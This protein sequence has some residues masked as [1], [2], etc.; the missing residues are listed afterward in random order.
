MFLGVLINYLDR[1]NISHTIL[2][3]SQELHLS[4]T[5]QGVILSS[6]S[7]GYVLFM[8]PSGWLV[9][10]Y[11]SRIVCA[12]SCIAWSVSTAMIG[13]AN[14]FT[15][16][17]VCR[18]LLGA[19]EAPIF[20]ANAKVVRMWFPIQERGRATAIFDAGSYVGAAIAAPLVVSVMLVLGWR[21]SFFTCAA[22][23]LLWS[24]VWYAY[25]RD[26]RSKGGMKHDSFTVEKLTLS[27]EPA[28]R[29]V[30]WSALFSSR[31]IWGMAFGF[32]CY[33]Y[34]K[35]FF[36]TWFPSYL[37][38]ERGFT[39]LKVGIYSFIPPLCAVLSELLAGV[40]TDRL[41]SRG[42]SVTLARKIPL[43]VGLIVSS[44]II[45]TAY[46]DSELSIIALMSLSY[47]SLIAASPSI[48]AIPGDVAPHAGLVGSI[49]G[50]QNTF[51]N[52]AGIIAPI[53][54]GAIFEGTGSFAI[55]LFISG[56]LIVLGA[57]SYWFVVG[58]L[59]PI[60]SSHFS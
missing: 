10:R 11:G 45:G 43:C 40:A 29:K 24:T 18:L 13:T 5:Q 59:E 26:P 8:L 4:P 55:P 15:S 39:I 60:R 14:N 51:S 3:M 46:V 56:I 23:G 19:T 35:S 58:E 33:N 36:L 49:G 27:S 6:F 47:A 9:D 31:K 7:W 54:T 1:V 48:W 37:V 16:F 44:A 52:L 22:T 20:P 32:F 2:L 41:I 21:A 57:A 38:E 53:I 28:L 25:Y 50:I 12:L 17:V 42:M 34:L 30:T